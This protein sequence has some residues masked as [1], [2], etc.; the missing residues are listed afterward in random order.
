MFDN[1]GKG[2]TDTTKRQVGSLF[3]S[4]TINGGVLALLIYFGNQVVN[5]SVE[6]EPVEVTFFDAAPPPPP[7][8]PPPGGKKTKT[9]KKKDKPK[10]VKPVEEV[11]PE[12]E[13]IEEPEEE[14]PEPEQVV[15]E[16]EEGE[17]GGQE[18]G[19][20]GGVVGGVVG[21]TVGGVL[22]GTLNGFSSVH[23]TDVKV[24]RRVP[25]KFPKA[26]KAAGITE[27]TCH[28]RF[29]V[30]TK[31]IPEKVEVEKCSKLFHASAI[32]AANKW[33]FYPLKSDSGQKQTATFIL[34][35]KYRLK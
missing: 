33:R 26:A 34:R 4:I 30:N 12:I 23:W 1:V 22:G 18:G 29:F 10:E 20:E 7:P 21:G 13:E 19:V 16:E 17:E 11:E 3:A 8:P 31:G 25:P 24:K 15:E 6:E 5:D 9:K 27:E 32:E 28:V 35:I 14:D 2:N